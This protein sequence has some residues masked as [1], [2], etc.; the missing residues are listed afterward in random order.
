MC[1]FADSSDCNS[2]DLFK[3]R[4][5][6]DCAASAKITSIPIIVPDLSYSI[7]EIFLRRNLICQAQIM[8]ERT[9]G[10]IML[11]S[12]NQPTLFVCQYEPDSLYQKTLNRHLIRI[13]DCNDFTIGLP[14]SIIEIPRLGVLV[15]ISSDVTTA[16][17]LSQTLHFLTASIIQQ[18]DSQFVLRVIHLQRA[19]QCSPQDISVLIIGD[20]ENID[21]WPSITIRAQIDRCALFQ[22]DRLKITKEKNRDAVNFGQQQHDTNHCVGPR[23]CANRMKYAPPRVTQ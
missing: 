13:K 6:Q 16:E 18:I 9:R 5:P 10:E 23:R 3:R 1:V 19:D 4:T 20:N 14:Q 15:I 7:E 2:A 17:L 11:R 21:C 12:L 8:F 22:F